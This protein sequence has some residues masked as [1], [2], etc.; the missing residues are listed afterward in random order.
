MTDRGRVFIER[1]ELENYRCFAKL[2]LPLHD[3]LTV[4]VAENGGGKTAILDALLVALRP[5]VDMIEEGRD[6]PKGLSTKDIRLAPRPDSSMEPVLPARLQVAMAYL[7]ETKLSRQQRPSVDR[8]SFRDDPLRLKAQEIIKAN[9]AYVQGIGDA[10]LFPLISYYGTGRLW[11][12]GKPASQARQRAPNARHR[13]YTECLSP[14]S[15]YKVF[16][17]WFRRFS[18]E[19]QKER[20][21]NGGSPHEAGRTLAVVREAVDVALAPSGWHGLEWDFVED[22]LVAHHKSHG[23]LV[24][25]M[26]SDGIRN[27]IGLVAD[28][29]HR[30]ARLN[31]QLGQRAA[32]ETAGIALIDEVDMHLHPAWQQEVIGSLQRAFP[33]VQFIVTTHSPQVLTTVPY[34]N[35]R[36]FADGAVHSAA[37]GTYGAE[38]Q[39][40][41][42][43]IFRVSPR[44]T[45]EMS[46][47]LDEY[48]RL[49][50]ARQWSSPRALELRHQLDEWS[51]GNEPSLLAA[52]L[53][54]DNMK[55]EAGQ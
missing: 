49:V 39:R 2:D 50:D 51:Q 7:G 8:A 45:N 11:A 38:A 19:T 23:R 1:L 9:T 15:H 55:W 24:V 43:S 37:P 30:T 25:D 27:M 16:I 17:D 29:A 53:E 35:I 21:V 14:S 52:D 20:N 5:F 42:E 48:M 28:I 41:L 31:P 46:A 32:L 54:I 26:L 33:L 34:E 44:P 6:R 4:L 47:A 3:R 40:I 10:P 13:G 36:I 18:Y 12:G 22:T